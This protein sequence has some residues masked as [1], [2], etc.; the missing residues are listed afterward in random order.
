MAEQTIRRKVDV[1]TYEDIASGDRSF[2]VC[3]QQDDIQ[4][5]DWFVIVEE[6]EDGQQ[7]REAYRK[8]SIVVEVEDTDVV[9]AGVVPPEYQSL[10]GLFRHNNIVMAY[11][12]EK[13]ADEVVLL[14]PPV[15]LPLLAAPLMNPNQ[16][17][18]FLGVQA[19]PDGQYSIML[20]CRLT[21]V[22]DGRQDVTVTEHMIMCRTVKQT[23]EEDIDA[24]VQVDYRFLALG[25]LR[26]VMGNIITAHIGPLEEEED[27]YRYD[28]GLDPD[29]TDLDGTEEDDEQV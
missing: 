9:I 4:P 18:D 12:V 23:E 26:D 28:D 1:E 19:W 22:Q 5:D 10:E 14:E 25:K 17:N 27:E 11:G 6:T 20:Y 8:V 16:M 29:E 3:T 24:F 21:P 15:Y 7:G 13:R 2:V